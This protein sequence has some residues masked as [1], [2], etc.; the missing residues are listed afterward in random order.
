MRQVTASL[1]TFQSVKIV[2]SGAS[3]YSGRRFSL[4]EVGRR[5]ENFCLSFS[6]FYI[7]YDI[8]KS[9]IPGMSKTKSLGISSVFLEMSSLRS[10]FYR[11]RQ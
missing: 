3:G 10:S 11:P 9:D 1:L 5:F 7:L 8:I 6:A 2:S 4:L